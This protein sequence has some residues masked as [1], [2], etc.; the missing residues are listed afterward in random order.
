[1][2]LSALLALKKSESQDKVVSL[3]SKTIELHL[4]TVRVCACALLTI[5]RHFLVFNDCDTFY[6]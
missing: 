1:M 5:L 4:G 3:L 6:S 2:Y